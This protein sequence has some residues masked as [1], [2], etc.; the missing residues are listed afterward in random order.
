[1]GL[2]SPSPSTLSQTPNGPRRTAIDMGFDLG[3]SMS[4]R[5]SLTRPHTI[6]KERKREQSCANIVCRAPNRTKEADRFLHVVR[7]VTQLR[8]DLNI[9]GTVVATDHYA[10]NSRKLADSLGLTSEHIEFLGEIGDLKPAYRQ[11]DLLVLTSDWE[12]T[13]NVLLEAMEMGFR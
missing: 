5:M 1:M 11:S 4:C 12:G 13:P 9:K 3:T 8:P 2:S 6:G 10:L 7:K